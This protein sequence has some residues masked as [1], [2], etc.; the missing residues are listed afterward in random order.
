[1]SST[2]ND[3]LTQA[4]QIIYGDREQTYGDP[5]HNLTHIA[6]QWRLYMLQ[7]HGVDIP[8]TYEDVCYMMADLKKCRQMNAHKQDNL[9]DGIGYLALIDRIV[10]AQQPVPDTPTKR[11]GVRGRGSR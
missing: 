4:H 6:Q 3:A 7:R 9:V 2:D 11:R 1:M 8:L 5:S 10:A